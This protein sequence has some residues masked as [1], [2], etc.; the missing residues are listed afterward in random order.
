MS[1]QKYKIF[2]SI[3]I[4]RLGNSES[5]FYIG[6]ESAGSLPTRPDGGQFEP[7]DFRD[8][9]GKLKRQ[10]ARFRIYKVDDNDGSQMEEVTLN[11]PDIVSINWTAH[12]AN[13][14]AIWYQFDGYLGFDGYKP[15][16]ILRNGKITDQAQRE[17][18]II[19][20]GP[21]TISGKNA[22]AVHF[23]RETTT[24]GSFPP[25]TLQPFGIDTLGELHTDD[26]GR[27]LLLGG[28]GH[29]GTD[30]PPPPDI[31]DFAN[32]DNWWD[33]TS[34][35][36]VTAC[37]TLTNG[38]TL[39][40]EPAWVIAGL[41]A[42]APEM[43]NVVTLYD[44]MFDVA[45]QK[46]KHRPDMYSDDKFIEG[47][48]G[49]KPDFL[50]EIKPLLLRGIQ[51]SGGAAISKDMHTFDYKI[52]GQVPSEKDGEIIDKHQLS[53]KFIY[54]IFRNLDTLNKMDSADKLG[55]PPGPGQGPT[56]LKGDH[57]GRGTL[58]YMP[59]AYGAGLEKEIEEELIGDYLTLTK[60]QLYIVKQWSEGF[61]E[62]PTTATSATGKGETI[63]QG[64]LENCVGGALHPGIE[65]TWISCLAEIY[66][67]PFRINKKEKI[68]YPLSLTTEKNG[69][70]KQEMEPGDMTKYM[71]LPW[72]ADFNNCNGNYSHTQ[73]SKGFWWWPAQRPVT[74]N[75][76]GAKNNP[77]PWVVNDQLGMVYHWSKLGFIVNEGTDEA[78]EYVE[79][80]RTLKGKRE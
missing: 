69:N 62:N 65:T 31:T 72:Q 37:I 14:K 34:D 18:M 73:Q 66:E 19:D 39:E 47:E 52:L 58:K 20:P 50:T 44:A 76:K 3:N 57:H 22:A 30:L 26:Q 27:L 59:G 60:T 7:A 68:P 43:E 8:A 54:N 15:D 38:E 24:K 74:V 17:A 75:V 42:F 9:E 80:E 51:A 2:P 35:G 12:I 64:V 46:L 71:A 53:R 40:V 1:T 29:S 5:D 49:Y 32:N 10:A 67:S 28:H 16:A 25:T 48:T 45:V 55:P 13:K 6:P 56:H 23:S 63:T 21:R 33:D 70:G 41:P 77:Q 61:F 79:V 78:P 11:S 4:A 36:P